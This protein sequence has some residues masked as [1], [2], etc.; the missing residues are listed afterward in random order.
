[1]Y[2]PVPDP[3]ELALTT[4]RIVVDLLA[5]L[6]G[7]D[8]L[9]RDHC[10]SVG[11]WSGMIAKTLGLDKSERKFA[12]L[13]GTLHDVGKIETPISILLKPG[14]LTPA[15]WTIMR[16]H[17]AA[18]AEMLEE[19][20][21][22]RVVA[23]IVRWHHERID[24][25]GYPDALAGDAIPFMARLVSV[26]DSFHAMTS[27]RPYRQGMPVCDAIAI[28]HAGRGTQW[29]VGIVDA[30]V[31]LVATKTKHLASAKADDSRRAS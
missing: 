29:D 30:M 24:G 5:R 10:R 7:R 2:Q 9:T 31:D 28:L 25:R 14:P 12:V 3:R 13:C 6:E 22:L 16:E 27:H 21:S 15:E 4:D 11:A 18:G 26:A 1:M 19:I 8:T 20:P 23:P 17:A